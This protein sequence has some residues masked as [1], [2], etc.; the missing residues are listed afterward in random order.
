LLPDA[1]AQSDSGDQF[2]RCAL[3][4]GARYAVPFASNHCFLHRETTRF[5]ST[6]TTPEDVR[7]HYQ[8]VATA[9]GRKSEC[10]V[11]PP[12]SSWSAQ[13]GFELLPFDF[14]ARGEYIDSMLARHGSRLEA[15]YRHEDGIEADFESFRTY[16][17]AMLRALPGFVRRRL[18]RPIVFNARD[19]RGA[20]YWLLDPR[21]AIV[22]ELIEPPT[23]LPIIEVHGAVLRDCTRNRM[24]SVWTASKR[25]RI[26]LP[27][28]SALTEVSRWFTILD[29]YELD[30]FPPSRNF[31][32]RALAIRLRRWREPVELA[33][34]V[35][36]RA[37]LR[38]PLTV[39]ALYPVKA[40]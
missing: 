3:H 25:L 30:M 6:A 2:V 24:F 33:L 12:G 5:N 4:V 32:P 27:Q 20:H 17:G 7:R 21:R 38:R 23:D 11:M 34:L 39:A 28:A 40:V 9:A 36:R 15:T 31:A 18:L 16:F 29:L 19:S 10:V 1:V 26:R 37:L 13:D 35:M 8:H 22:R 14:A